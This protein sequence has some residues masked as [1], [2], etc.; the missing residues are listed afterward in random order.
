MLG[1]RFVCL[2]KL[3]MQLELNG[4]KFGTDLFQGNARKQGDVVFCGLDSLPLRR[5][6]DFLLLG[7]LLAKLRPLLLQ[8]PAGK[9]EL[10]RRNVFRVVERACG[11]LCQFT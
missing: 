10:I 7:E 2:R 1:G 6:V 5:F 11:R 8:L 4:C 3:S 9:L